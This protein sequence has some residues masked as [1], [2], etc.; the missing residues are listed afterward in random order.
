MDLRE[1][2]EIFRSTGSLSVAGPR[3]ISTPAA[4]VTEFEAPALAS[5]P[6]LWTWAVSSKTS[7]GFAR[8]AQRELPFC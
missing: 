5:S 8:D 3:E 7:I 4:H 2:P 1:R 6:R